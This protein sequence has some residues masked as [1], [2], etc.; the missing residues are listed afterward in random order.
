MVAVAPLGGRLADRRGRRA[1]A[2]GGLSLLVVAT[3]ALAAMGSAPAAAGL[4]GALL[5]G[6]IGLGLSGAA[7]QTAAMEAVEQRHA[8]VAAGLYSTGRYAGAIVSAGLLAAL[9]GHGTQHAGAFFAVT[10]AAAGA[11]TLLA[12]RLGPPRREVVAARA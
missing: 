5:V 2:V 7:I 12:L 8:G 9:L 6:G 11:A 3:G 4:V 1:P 10:C